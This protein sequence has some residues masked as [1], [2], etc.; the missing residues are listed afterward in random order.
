MLAIEP[1]GPQI[2]T[3]GYIDQLRIET[4]LIA[5][6]P[7]ATVNDKAHAKGAPYIGQNDRLSLV[8]EDR[9]ASDDIEA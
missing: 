9:V 2:V 1:I 8:C 5:G 3:C 4:D 6:T 7:D